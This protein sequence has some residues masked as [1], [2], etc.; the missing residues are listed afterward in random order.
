MS[1]ERLKEAF[2]SGQTTEKS[3]Q[4]ENSR[5]SKARGNMIFRT[6]TLIALPLLWAGYFYSLLKGNESNMSSY[7]LMI[8]MFSM[9]NA[10]VLI[11]GKKLENKVLDILAKANCVMI[12]IWALVTVVQLLMK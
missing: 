6:I 10:D 3:L 12:F 4:D 11:A 7:T 9:L 8:L 5:M 1:E 2:A